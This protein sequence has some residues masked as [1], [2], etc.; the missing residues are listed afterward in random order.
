MSAPRKVSVLVLSWN[1]REHLEHCL[2]ALVDQRAPGVPWEILLL[3]NGSADGTV[4]WV[5]RAHPAVRVLA[6]ERNLGFC[7]G[8]QRLA[9]AAE[10]DALVLLNNDTRPHAD[11]LGE[12]VAAAA[13]APADVA[14]VSGLIVD[15]E[16]ERLDFGRGV[17]TFDGHAFQLD[18][19]RP[20]ASAALPVPGE[21][22][23]FACG[24]NMLVRRDSFLA[25]GGFDPDYFAYYEDVD[26]GWRLWSGG[27]RVIAAPRAVVRHR[28]SGTSDRL[29]MYNRGLLFERNA[30]A[31]VH[32]NLESGLWEQLMPAVLLTFLARARTLL[33]EGNRGGATLTEDPYRQGSVAGS[34]GRQP[35]TPDARWKRFARRALTGAARRLARLADPSGELVGRLQAPPGGG[36]RVELDDPRSIAQL[37]AAHHLLAGLDAVTEKRRQIQARR[38][39]SDR[40]W[41]GRFP[42]YL[43]PTYPGDADLFASA[44]FRS[45]LPPD[46]PLVERSLGEIM[47]LGR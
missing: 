1:G 13:A 41:L 45:W 17:V 43:V 20:L 5:R 28:S 23:P 6:S 40:E 31:T 8:N 39:R 34:A 15:W 42:F 3:D 25:A 44:G 14:A 33:V 22:M 19:R 30:F 35:G 32:K 2:P 21:E 18:H 29:G 26:L 47:E 10:G 46:L 16:G 38:R 27:E 12:L 9:E 7:A 11:W 24:G 37:R 4:E 36:L